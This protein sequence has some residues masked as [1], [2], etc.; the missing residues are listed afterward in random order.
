MEGEDVLGVLF[1]LLGVI[2][3]DEVLREFSDV[4][5]SSFVGEE[6][7][8]LSSDGS[9]L[10]GLSIRSRGGR[11]LTRSLLGESKSEDSNDVTVV[12]LAV[13][14]SFNEGLPLSDHRA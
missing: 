2:F 13:N 12:G 4:G 10:R 8:N 5:L 3:T 6:G 1:D 7:V 14:S 11:L 9:D